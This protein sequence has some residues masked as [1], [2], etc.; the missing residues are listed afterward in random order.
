M[1]PKNLVRFDNPRITQ[2]LATLYEGSRQKNLR[3][4][5]RT[6]VR[7][8]NQAPSEFEKTRTFAPLNVRAKKNQKFPIPG[9]CS[10]G[11]C[12]CAQV[13]HSRFYGDDRSGWHTICVNNSKNWILMKANNLSED[14]IGRLVLI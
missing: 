10:K 11:A 5:G 7:K 9:L 14:L 13:A 1:T 8:N 3:K 2:F 6:W 12:F 4:F